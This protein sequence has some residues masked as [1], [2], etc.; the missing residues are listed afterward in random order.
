MSGTMERDGRDDCLGNE[1]HD[2]IHAMLSVLVTRASFGEG[3]CDSTSAN[4]EL[5][6]QWP[7]PVNMTTQWPASMAG[8][9]EKM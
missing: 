8:R 2:E 9:L 5:F 6:P 7:Q 3:E 4:R 1:A